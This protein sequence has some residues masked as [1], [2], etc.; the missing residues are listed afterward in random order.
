MPNIEKLKRKGKTIY[1][2]TIPKAVVDPSTGRAINA[3]ASKSYNGLVKLGSDT[4]Q[5]VAAGTPTATSSR[6]YPIQ[7][8]SAGELVVNVPWANT[9]YNTSTQTTNG[10][11]SAADKKKLDNFVKTITLGYVFVTSELEILPDDS[12]DNVE[13][14]YDAANQVISNKGILEIQYKLSRYATTYYTSRAIQCYKNGD[15]IYFTFIFVD[16][17]KIYIANLSLME[18]SWDFSV[19]AELKGAQNA[20]Y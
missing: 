14:V 17:S 1:P 15:I 9:T 3:V 5:T 20:M 10:L 8:N 19:V 6:T 11:M 7:K 2:A 16:G 13:D 12:W 4:V 18:D